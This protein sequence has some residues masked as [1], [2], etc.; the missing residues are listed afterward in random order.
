MVTATQTWAPAAVNQG[1]VPSELRNLTPTTPTRLLQSSWLGGPVSS[2]PW[3]HHHP[4]LPS[5]VTRPSQSGQGVTQASARY[6]PIFGQEWHALGFGLR[7]LWMQ[8][9]LRLYSFTGLAYV[10]GL[11]APILDI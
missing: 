1:R 11:V 2:H 8:K 6:T 9:E 10:Y 3:V 4:P 5:G 7:T